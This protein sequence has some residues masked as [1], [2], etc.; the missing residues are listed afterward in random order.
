MNIQ[1]ST[2][3]INN[4]TYVTVLLDAPNTFLGVPRK[5]KMYKYK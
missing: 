1:E 3:L 2:N 5:L 4:E